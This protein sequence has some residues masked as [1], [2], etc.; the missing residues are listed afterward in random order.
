MFRTTLA[1]CALCASPALAQDPA[2]M[3]AAPMMATFVDAKGA[4]TGSAEIRPAAGGGV[5]ISV[6][7]TGLPEGPLGF[8]IHETGACDAA[9]EFASAGGHYN[10]DGRGHG[11]LNP[12]GPH[13]GDMPNQPVDAEGRMKVEVLNPLISPED[14]AGRAIMIHGHADDYLSDPTGHAG[15]RIAC[16][17]VEAAT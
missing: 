9:G 17:V 13:A 3:P 8:H 10:P 15:G 1:A 7:V 4:E 16:A 5:L 11:I 6:D 2:P 14:M 12:E